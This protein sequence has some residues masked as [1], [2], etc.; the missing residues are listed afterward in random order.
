ML[1]A[2]ESH[3]RQP[4]LGL[5]LTFNK[6]PLQ[7]RL[8][9][10]RGGRTYGRNLRARRALLPTQ[11]QLALPR[12]ADATPRQSTAQSVALLDTRFPWLRGAEKRRVR[13]QF[14]S[15]LT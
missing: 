13:Q 6:S 7:L 10:A 11:P 5:T 1:R 2:S 15:S 8:I 12:A 14:T 3:F 9:G 4:V